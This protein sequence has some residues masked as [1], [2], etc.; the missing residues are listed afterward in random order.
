V[1]EATQTAPDWSAWSQEAVRLMQERNCTW[2]RSYSLEGHPYQWSLDDAELVFR[3]ESDEVV[4]D[5]CVIGSVSR[6][7]GTFCWAWANEAIPSCAQHDLARV[8]EFGKVRALELL[9][10]P[11]WPGGRPEGLEMAA[12]AGRILDADGI[13]IEETGDVTLFFACQIFE[14]AEA[15]GCVKAASRLGVCRQTPAGGQSDAMSVNVGFHP[16]SGQGSDI[17]S[18]PFRAISDIEQARQRP[19]TWVKSGPSR[20]LA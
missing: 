16:E 8:R 10:K 2:A 14:D 1:S 18:C 17:A 5:I 15:G 6:S 19:P 4:S 13:W 12:V 3:C 11:Q 9:I 20:M 7:E